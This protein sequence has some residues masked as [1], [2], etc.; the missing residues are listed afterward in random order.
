MKLTRFCEDCGKELIYIQLA[1]DRLATCDWDG[2]VPY[3]E[4][5]NGVSKV[6][7]PYRRIV[8]CDLESEGPASGE[9]Y[10]LH[11]CDK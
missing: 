11:V 3:W 5:P 9:G 8:S 4:N 1:N 10:V 6:V 2:P 7:T